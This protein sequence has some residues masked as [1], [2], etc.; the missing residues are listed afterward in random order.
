MIYCRD[1]ITVGQRATANSLSFISV[2]L[3]KSDQEAVSNRESEKP[4]YYIPNYG[5]LLL[6]G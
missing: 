2:F 1:I 3:S 6:Y 5:I 4:V